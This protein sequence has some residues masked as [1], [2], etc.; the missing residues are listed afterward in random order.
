MTRH[1]L[2]ASAPSRIDLAGGTLDLWPLYLFCKD[3]V[4]LNVAIDCYATVRLSPRQDGA[5]L[6][7]S[8][9]QGRRWRGAD[10]EALQRC[11]SLPMLRA[12]L[13]HELRQATA[14]HAA[15][16]RAGLTLETD[17]Q[18]PAGSGLGGSSALLVA[19]LAALR[20]FLGGRLNL[21]G[22]IQQAQNL[23]T[24]II[25]AP[26][27]W[28]D[29]YPAA[30]GGVQALWGTP[31]GV[32]RE[33]LHVDLEAL[34]ERLLLCYTGVPRRSALN[35]WEVFRG[36]FDGSQALRR[37][38]G[39]IAASSL[40]LY[41][42]LSAGRLDRLAA[43]IA[44]EWSYRRRLS[45]GTSTPGIECLGRAAHRAGAEAM[46]VCGAGGGGC[47]FFVTP[48]AKR[49]AVRQAITAAGGRLLD[50]RLA[51]RGVRCRRSD[52]A[53]TVSPGESA[54]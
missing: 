41:E 51:R 31:A 37:L 3:A 47:V 46:K 36:F 15:P 24:T 6:L 45:R 9:D 35:N 29:Y 30:Y 4:T 43:P 32:R 21:P 39:G 16:P 1:P 42:E 48:P 23:E 38:L 27:G 19:L 2:E 49:L 17:C 8:L 54:A 7:R 14:P 28:Q 33:A 10:V 53:A 34:G 12:A 5:I 50:I 22:L 25:Q 18:A 40:R 11:R 52:M 44:A 26:T 13:L 20:R